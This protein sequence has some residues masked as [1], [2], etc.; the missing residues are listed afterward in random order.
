MGQ[1]LV[2]NYLHITFST[3]HRLPFIYP[4]VNKSLY[5]YLVAVCNELECQPLEIGGFTDHVHILCMLSKKLALMDFLREM[6]ANSSK[7]LKSFGNGYED[8]Y[9]QD[10]YAAFSV[11]PKEIDAVRFYI[12]N[13]EEHHQ[14][15]SFQDELRSFMHRYNIQ[16][17]ERYVWD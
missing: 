5:A 13:Q 1:S 7:W 14:N 12:S 10:G 6:K 4:P 15:M 11:N 9:W 2:Q 8:F 3:K 16:Y 17:D